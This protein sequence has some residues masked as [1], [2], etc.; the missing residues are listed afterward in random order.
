MNLSD[1][2]RLARGFRSTMR[3][4][5]ALAVWEIAAWFPHSLLLIS[6]AVS[7]GPWASGCTVVFWSLGRFSRE[8]VYDIYYAVGGKL[9][10]PL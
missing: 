9:V 10:G 6:A 7:C 2:E 1:E 5:K 4:T 3:S 8:G